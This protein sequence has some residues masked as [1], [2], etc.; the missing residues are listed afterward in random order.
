MPEGRRA[1]ARDWEPMTDRPAILIAEDD[2]MIALAL[3][4]AA[5]DC[6]AVVQGPYATVAEAIERIERDLPQA[7][8]LDGNLR[9]GPVTPLARHLI[10]LGVPLLIHSA[11]PIPAK[12][13]SEFPRLP[14]MAKPAPPLAVISRLL[15]LS[16]ER[17]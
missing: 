10:H 11:H 17:I 14:V 16:G 15:S 6:G 8:L 1:P 7:A 13:A 4:L 2:A 3:E 5:I 12:L 9:D